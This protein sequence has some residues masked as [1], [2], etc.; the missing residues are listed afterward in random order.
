MSVFCIIGARSGSKSILDKNLQLIGNKSLLRLCVE[1]ALRSKLFD[2]I[3]LSTDSEKYAHEIADLCNVEYVI[4]PNSI[5]DDFS[6]EF[7]YLRHIINEKRINPKDT[8]ARMQ[9]TSPF[10]SI[11]SMSQCLKLLNNSSDCTSV[12]LV[13]EART[14]LY[15]AM[16]F[17]F[18]TQRLVPAH[19]EGSISPRNRQKFQKSYFRSNFYCL[20]LRNVSYEDF[21]GNNSLGFVGQDRECIDID[22][23][24]DL[25]L[26]RAMAEKYPQWLIA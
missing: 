18:G 5:S 3:Y 25:E 4:R 1:K 6:H 2:K 15:K 12:Q 17:D 16:Q 11:E 24:F 26:V 21:I 10:Q 7:D 22:S 19:P 14:S 13:T 9:C 20:K 23:P 8:I